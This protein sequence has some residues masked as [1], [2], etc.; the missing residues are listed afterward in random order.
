MFEPD[1]IPLTAAAQRLRIT[2]E[3]ARKL[4]FLGTLEGRQI[5]GSNRWV[6]TRKSIEAERARRAASV[7]VPA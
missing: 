7:A 6:I 2:Y 1:E 4:V 3:Q 5:P